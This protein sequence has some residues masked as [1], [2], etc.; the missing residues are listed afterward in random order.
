MAGNALCGGADKPAANA[1]MFMD[2]KC[3]VQAT[4]ESF[5]EEH[6]GFIKTTVKSVDYVKTT[7]FFYKIEFNPRVVEVRKP[8][9]LLVGANAGKCAKAISSLKLVS[10]AKKTMGRS[11]KIYEET[12]Q[13]NNSHKE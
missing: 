11:T 1:L 2:S 13:L 10:N 3:G 9:Q 5:V 4:D 6:E 12:V 7:C 8:I